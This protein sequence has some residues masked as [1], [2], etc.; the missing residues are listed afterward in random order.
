MSDKRLVMVEWLDAMGVGQEWEELRSLA[1]RTHAI[2]IRSVGWVVLENSAQLILVP[3]IT[4]H[5]NED[6][7]QGCGEMA[8]PRDSVVFVRDL[9]AQKEADRV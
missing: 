1:R 4:R 3:H 5:T 7:R 9:E 8:I 2:R 6:E